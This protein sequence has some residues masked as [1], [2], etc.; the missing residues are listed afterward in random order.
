MIEGFEGSISLTLDFWDGSDDGEW[1][2]QGSSKGP[3]IILVVIVSL[4]LQD[5][6][7]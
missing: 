7:L 3:I 4:Q 2:I 5:T 6:M 1:S